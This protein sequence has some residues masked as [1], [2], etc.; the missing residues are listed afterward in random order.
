MAKSAYAQAMRYGQAVF[1]IAAQHQNF[2]TC[3]DNMDTLVR[4]VQDRDV[5]Y[6]LE[7]PRIPIA[8]K[9]EVL[10]P[11]LKGVNPMAVNLLYLLPIYFPH[12]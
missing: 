2:N 5:L 7:N 11:K 3:R 8:K 6:F 10:E 9:R 4:M 1:E 12:L